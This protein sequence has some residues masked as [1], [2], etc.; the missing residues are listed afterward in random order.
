MIGGL[1][2]P[3]MPSFVHRMAQREQAL[4]R[5]QASG[6]PSPWAEAPA[7]AARRGARVGE[8]VAGIRAHYTGAAM[9]A[10]PATGAQPD[11]DQWSILRSAAIRGCATAEQLRSALEGA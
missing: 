2:P 3:A 6:A 4:M 1:V 11:I 5:V 8:A 10:W 7:E 9:G